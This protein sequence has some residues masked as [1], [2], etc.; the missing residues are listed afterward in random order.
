[1]E[2]KLTQDEIEFL[3]N[4]HKN[5]L[6]F[7]K[8]AENISNLHSEG[9]IGINDYIEE[10]FPFDKS[11]NEINIYEWVDTSVSKIRAVLTINSLL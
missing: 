1:M 4:L 5:L 8:A 3:L 2:K 7:R 6:E 11:F 10:K 9:R